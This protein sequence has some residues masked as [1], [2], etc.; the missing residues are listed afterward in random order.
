MNLDEVNPIPERQEAIRQRQASIKIRCH[1][2]G[3]VESYDAAQQTV[4]VRVAVRECL[5]DAAGQEK[6]TEIPLLL[7]VPMVFPRAGGYVL[8]LPITR[9]DEVLVCFGDACIDAWWQSGGVQNQIDTRRHDLSDAFAIPGPWSQPRRVSNYSTNSCQ[10][11]NEAGDAY[12]EII[13]NV[14]NIKAAGG[15]HIDS[16]SEFTAESAGNT[17]IHSNSA[18]NMSSVS[19]S[20]FSGSHITIG[21]GGNTVIDDRNFLTHTHSG[22]EPGG[23]STGGVN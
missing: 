10:L 9:G 12:F 4:N 5:I 13:G 21:S 14:I 2:P 6:W 22:V 17:E 8:T 15:I 16:G 18:L 1:I 23:G 20:S 19:R 3:I 11:R 7:D